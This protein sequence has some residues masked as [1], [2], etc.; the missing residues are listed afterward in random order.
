MRKCG[1]GLSAL[2]LYEDDFN[3]IHR[4]ACCACKRCMQQGYHIWRDVYTVMVGLCL[5]D[6]QRSLLLAGAVDATKF[7]CSS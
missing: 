4:Q 5:C 2:H 1:C 7:L 6:T 3:T